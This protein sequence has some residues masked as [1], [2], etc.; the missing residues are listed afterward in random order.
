MGFVYQIIEPSEYRTIWISNHR[1]EQRITLNYLVGFSFKMY[2][3]LIIFSYETTLQ[4]IVHLLNCRKNYIYWL[5]FYLFI[6]CILD[7]TS[8]DGWLFT[9]LSNL[10]LFF[11]RFWRVELRGF[12]LHVGVPRVGLWF[13]YL[14][15]C[16]VNGFY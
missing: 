10:P 1:F 8:S 11:F 2:C 15:Y 7:P 14:D 4:I 5:L 13:K 6:F 9:R 3:T 12:F 16:F